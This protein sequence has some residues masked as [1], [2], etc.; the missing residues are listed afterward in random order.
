M[1]YSFILF[2]WLFAS[3]AWC[4][5]NSIFSGGIGAGGANALTEEGVT[6]NS[7]FGGGTGGDG[8]VQELDYF[9]GG[10][11]EALPV[12]LLS[13]EAICTDEGLNVQWATVT[14]VNSEEFVLY[15]KHALEAPF[16]KIA[17]IPAAGFSV[18]V[19]HYEVL[20][21]CSNCQEAYYYLKWWILMVVGSVQ[22]FFKR[23]VNLRMK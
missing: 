18:T 2:L 9:G 11:N 4:Q 20:D 5:N 15:R 16:E 21:K 6:N 10:T 1:R 8:V 12:E 3:H 22:I 17:I 19:R 13:F 14:E 7:V 23:A